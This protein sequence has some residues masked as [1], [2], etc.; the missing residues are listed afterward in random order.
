[1]IKKVLA[2]ALLALCAG[3]SVTAK[4]YTVSSP[5]G[6]LSAKVSDRGEISIEHQGKSV[7]TVRA[8][9]VQ[10]QFSQSKLAVY[11]A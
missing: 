3:N 2:A 5:N 1:M 10:K 8:D 4:D 6:R 9:L 11:P 7:L